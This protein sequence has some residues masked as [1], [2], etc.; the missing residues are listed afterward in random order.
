MAVAASTSSGSRPTWTGPSTWPPRRPRAG[1]RGRRAVPGALLPDARHVEVQ[2]FGGRRGRR[3]GRRGPG[4]LRAATSPEGAGGGP[5]AGAVPRDPCAAARQARTSGPPP[6]L[7][8]ARAPWSSGRRQRGADPA[9]VVFLEVNGP[10]SRSSTRSPRSC[11][12]STWSPRSCC[13]PRAFHRS[14][15]VAARAARARGRVPGPAED[16]WA[17]FA[18]RPARITAVVWPAGPGIGSTPTPPTGTS[19]ALLRQPAGQARRPG[20]RPHCGPG[21]HG[22]RARQRPGRRHRH[23]AGLPGLAGRPARRPPRRGHHPVV[24]PVWPEVAGART[25]V[26]AA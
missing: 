22:R 11:S 15:R 26:G 10:A 21:R 4:L 6:A 1:V 19:S 14:A 13:S 3:P 8:R 20:P 5:G 2:V 9:T 24:G 17:G 25:A 16:A 12:A 18:P 23:H 7:H